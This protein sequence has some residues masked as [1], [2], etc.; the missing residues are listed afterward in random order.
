MQN[1]NKRYNK[2]VFLNKQE[3]YMKDFFT[4]NKEVIKTLIMV[5]LAIIGVRVPL[6]IRESN[7]PV[8]A[9]AELIQSDDYLAVSLMVEELKEF[10]T[11]EEVDARIDVW[12][13]QTWKIQTGIAKYIVKKPHLKE[14]LRKNLVYP[15]VYTRFIYRAYKLE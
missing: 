4:K 15:E 7:D 1:L 9:I 13:E 8:S 12:V 6:E 5:F 3:E 14:S 11:A 2:L 10:S